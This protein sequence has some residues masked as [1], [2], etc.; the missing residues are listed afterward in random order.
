[1]LLSTTNRSGVLWY[2]YKLVS[3]SI[4]PKIELFKTDKN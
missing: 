1:M 3:P 4:K 2:L